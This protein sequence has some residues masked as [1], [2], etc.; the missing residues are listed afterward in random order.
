MPQQILLHHKFVAA[1]FSPPFP[2]IFIPLTLH[3]DHHLIVCKA[4]SKQKAK[5]IARECLCGG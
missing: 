3:T 1:L 5:T 2:F 4:P